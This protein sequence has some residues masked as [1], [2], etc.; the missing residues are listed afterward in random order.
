MQ[1]VR[2]KLIFKINGKEYEKDKYS[3]QTDNFMI[4][5]NSVDIKK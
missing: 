3:F 1:K 4:N 5:I 2:Q